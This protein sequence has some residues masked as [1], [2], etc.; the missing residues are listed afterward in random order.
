MF[1]GC[2]LGKWYYDY[3]YFKKAYNEAVVNGKLFDD[4]G[5][6]ITKILG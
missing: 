6:K 3:V 4:K 1:K 5:N 2:V